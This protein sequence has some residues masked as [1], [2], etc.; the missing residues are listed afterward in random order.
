MKK[1][2]LFSSVVRAFGF[3]AVVGL[4]VVT[5]VSAKEKHHEDPTKIVTKVGAGYSDSAFVSGSIGL[6]EARMINARYNETGEWRLGGS[7]LF[8]LGILNF[9]FSRTDYENDSY[10]NNYS[11]GTYIPLSYF[12][13]SPAG[14]MLFP[15]AGYSY[16]D[17]KM[18]MPSEEVDNEYVL[19]RSQS[20]GGY[21]GMFGIRPIDDS[22]WSVLGFAGGSIGSDNYRG[23]W[24]GLGLS[25]KINNNASFNFFGMLS[26]DDY[27]T[28]NKLAG[29]VSYEF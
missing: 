16:N 1:N 11:I 15:M 10:R 23:Y 6:D 5:G 3:V 26:E 19:M 7:W 4:L 12:D 29:S 13:I 25:Y 22:D 9:N 8:D 17:G 14:W 2:G 18:A 20:H 24:G 27:G 21:L 28:N